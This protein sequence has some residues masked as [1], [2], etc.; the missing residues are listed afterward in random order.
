MRRQADDCVSMCAS[1]GMAA[2]GRIHQEIYEDEFGIDVWDRDAASRCFV[3]IAN[4]SAYERMTGNPPPS[5][6]ITEQ[7]Y[8]KQGIPWFM[9]YAENGKALGGGQFDQLEDVRHVSSGQ[10]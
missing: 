8:H 1:M 7:E 9:H 4:S 5:T 2:G 3:H 6:P 10:W